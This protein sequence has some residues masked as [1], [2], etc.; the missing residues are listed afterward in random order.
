MATPKRWAVRDVASATFIGLAGADEGKVLA[1]TDTLKS[2]GVETSSETVYARG[3]TGNAKL[4]GFSSDKECMVNL[5][6]AIFTN[7]ILALLTGND[8]T[9]GA[10]E[11]LKRDVLYVDATNKVVLNFTPATA[12]EL[13]AV[14]SLNS[15]GSTN[16][17]FT[18]K[19]ESPGATEYTISGKNVTFNA[20]VEEGTPIAV[21][22]YVDTDATAQEI[23]VTADSFGGSFKL[24]LDVLVTSY[25]D[26]A[27][28]PAQIEI[29]NAKIE[30]DWEITFE[31]TGDPAVLD[32]PIE[33][34]KA[35]IGQDMWTMTV[36]NDAGIS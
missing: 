35:P 21:H 10:K 25:G 5:Q 20:A 1:Y 6:D 2:S 19:A 34:L 8:I 17:E 26:K 33:V 9:E 30:D 28:Y 31:P 15:D 12:G 32:I 7:E 27:L 11:V 23:K 24:I 13:V 36:Y 29:P 14:N 3:G 16:V 18:K 4:I 22:Y